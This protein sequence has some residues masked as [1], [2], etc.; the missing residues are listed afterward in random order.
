MRR[1][2]KTDREDLRSRCQSPIHN[3][4]QRFLARV[5]ISGGVAPAV[6]AGHSAALRRLAAAVQATIVPPRPDRR[7]ETL[8]EAG[9]LAD[10]ALSDDVLQVLERANSRGTL[11]GTTPSSVSSGPP[12]VGGR[13]RATLSAEKSRRRRPPT[14]EP[15]AGIWGAEGSDELLD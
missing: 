12:A 11:P 2:A 4:R 13:P 5:E 8:N 9:E 1:L 14:S 10:G 6:L 3:E 15:L 7:L